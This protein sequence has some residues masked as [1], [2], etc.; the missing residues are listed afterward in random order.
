MTT[1]DI[2][3]SYNREDAATAKR[4][5]DA[6]AAE[7]L[8]VWWD[9]ALRSGEAYDEVT[10]AALRGAKAVVVLWSPRS[11]VSRW[12]RAE[13]TIADRCKTLVPVTIEACER[14]IMFELTQTADLAH[15]A[16]D[17]GDK[18]WQAFVSDVKRFV[19]R[20][21]EAQATPIAATSTRPDRTA[22]PAI[23]D[24]S[25]IVVLPFRARES[26]E[27]EQMTADGLTDD[28]TMLLTSVKGMNVVPRTSV[29]RTLG[30][31]DSVA[32]I[33]VTHGS[34]YAVTGSVRRAGDKLRVSVELID[35]QDNQQ[36]WSQRF[37]RATE[38][39]FAIQDE[40]A[41]GVVIALGGVITRAEGQRALRAHPD[42]LQAWELTRRALSVAWDWRPETLQQGVNDLRQ[43]LAFDPNYAEAH[44]WLGCLLA[45]RSICGWSDNV[46][47]EQAEAIRET[48]ESIRLGYDSGAALWSAIQSYWV[49]GLADR[50][51][52]LYE[53]SI[54]R[55]PDI[56][57]AWPFAIGGAGVGYAR[58]GR[59]EEGLA[60]IGQFES[61]FPNDEWG[62]VWTRVFV[63][64]A[65]L[66]RGNYA[67][68]AEVLVNSPS[69]HDG[70]CQVVALLNLQRMDDAKA[71]FARLKS[72]N[73]N[74]RLDRYIEYFKTYCADPARNE[75]MS[76]GLAQLRDALEA[77]GVK[78]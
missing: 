72:R 1:P 30:L 43:A 24:G 26:D 9:T 40:I 39:I 63:G 69:E 51:V 67:R 29:Q 36:K 59:V 20:N 71:Q 21:V 2:F 22:I 76:A 13:A 27:I 25:R 33:A 31:N 75:E 46:D 35:V 73:P 61:G 78:P 49:L 7:G 65:E 14:P 62:A 4:F 42:S 58:A 3:L 11:V 66:C 17:S 60:L 28:V 15:W 74:I 53:R 6:F 38:D 8:N 18:A 57:L 50:S 23:A 12:V 64:Y 16:G 70:M 52:E 54:A 5:A 44:A 47:L 48:D 77:G 55:Q 32:Q 19:G 37:D 56:F 45:W 68:V 41:R 34:R 10:E